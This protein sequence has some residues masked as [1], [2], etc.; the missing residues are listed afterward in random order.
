M[1]IL[2]LAFGLVVWPGQVSQAAPMGTA[3]TYQGRLID[4]NNEAEGLYDFQ[5]KL[6]DADA[7]GN[8]LG[9]DAN[10][11]DVDVID[12]Y[13][14]VE[15]DFG[16]GV[17]DGNGV[18]LDVGIRSG[19]LEDP[20]TFA[21]LSPRQQLTPTPYAAYTDS[22]D[23][24]NITNIPPD[25]DDGDNDTVLSEAQVDSYVANNG[26]LTSYSETDPVFTASDAYSITRSQITN[27]DTAYGW[28]NHASA[29]YLISESDP[30]VGSISS[31]YVPK[32]SGSVLVTGTIYDNGNVGIGTASPISQLDIRGT[33][34]PTHGSDWAEISI[35]DNDNDERRVAISAY[36]SNV[37]AD[38]DH[39]GIAFK[40]HESADHTVAPV[41][42]MVIDYDGSIGIGTTSP[43]SKLKV[44]GT[45]HSTTGGF[46]FPD[47]SVQTTAASGA[48]D[49]DTLDG[50]HGS[51]YRDASN[52]NAGTL[53]DA[54]LTSNVTKLGSSI[55]SSEIVDGTILDVDINT[56]AGI[57]PDKVSGTAATLTGDQD[58]DSGTLYIDAANNRVGIGTTTPQE[59]VHISGNTYNSG[60]AYTMGSVGVGTTN[61]QGFKVYVQGDIY[62]TG[63]VHQPSDSRLKENITPLRDPVEKVSSL[64]GV[65][66]N[67]KGQSS[68]KREVG[69]IAQDVEAV[70][71]ELV[72]EDAQ[73]YKSV[74][75]SRLT[76]LLIEAV[77]EQQKQIEGLQQ[78]IELLEN[79]A[80]QMRPSR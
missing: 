8:Q 71:P 5:F 41:T 68:C 45:I 25:I 55:A 77:K 53:S 78:R 39:M 37:G 49:A 46:K 72:S 74:A 33:D 21:V 24:A 42:Q 43:D 3:F 58:F 62:L 60:N 15:L 80:S 66:F 65:Y 26:Y 29:G 32:S 50:Q 57:A 67:Y 64:C 11:P 19:E 47:G 16:S 9:G 2:V 76:A 63:L 28:G 56:D 51:F 20:N 31:N 27:W 22:T 30:Q 12:G 36:R 7:N 44:A 73:G 10:L 4:A 69:V 1:T 59:E 38:W 6:F 35:G 34:N 70:L 48:G 75:Y 18:W 61:T 13:F 17:F 14:T 23:W 40:T 79:A 54:R 52:I